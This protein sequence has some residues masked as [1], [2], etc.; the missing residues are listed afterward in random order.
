MRELWFECLI[1]SDNSN[2]T[3]SFCQLSAVRLARPSQ[4][5]QRPYSLSVVLQILNPSMTCSNISSWRLCSQICQTR[6]IT[7]SPES[8]TCMWL[9]VADS[10]MWQIQECD[11]AL[12]PSR[13]LGNHVSTQPHTHSLSTWV[14]PYMTLCRALSLCL[15]L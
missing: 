10:C 3:R 8:A 12:Y 1:D 2:Y 6:W 9:S 4:S 7:V 11:C 15:I 13:C 5:S 14:C